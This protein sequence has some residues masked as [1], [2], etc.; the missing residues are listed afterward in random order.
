MDA[1]VD[2]KGG[3]NVAEGLLHLVAGAA[4]EGLLGRL[5]QLG[6]EVV[7]LGG[8]GKAVVVHQAEQGLVGEPAQPV[9]QAGTAAELMEGLEQPLLAAVLIPGDVQGQH[10]DQGAGQAHVV[11]FAGVAGQEGQDA[12]LKQLKGSGPVSG[13]QLALQLGHHRQQLAAPAGRDGPGQPGQPP[14]QVALE[15]AGG[16]VVA[17][18]LEELEDISPG[19]LGVAGGVGVPEDGEQGAAEPGAGVHLRQQELA[20]LALV[21]LQHVQKGAHVA[22][23]A[24]LDAG[25]DH[26]PLVDGEELAH[27]LRRAGGVHQ[28]LEEGGK[29]GVVAQRL[30]AGGVASGLLLRPVVRA[31]HPVQVRGVLNPGVVGRHGH[32]PVYI[33]IVMTR[34]RVGHTKQIWH[35]GH[36]ISI[37]FFFFSKNL[38]FLIDTADISS[39]IV[40]G[41]CTMR[42]WRTPTSTP[43]T[44]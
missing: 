32:I 38:N 39:M 3:D 12:A 36:S 44:K 4:L 34:Y 33:V 31:D 25:G 5:G 27:A 8:P 24:L 11:G 10:G 28:A 6:G 29:V 7:P 42:F 22:G 9:F 13:V 19:G 14:Q 30:A 41:G 1:L 23:G 2:Q 18:A 17:V 35:W 20:Q 40:R 37:K 16:G 26:Q 43:K 21:H 15:V